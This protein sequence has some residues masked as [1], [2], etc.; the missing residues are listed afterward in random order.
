MTQGTS[1]RWTIHLQ[2]HITSFVSNIVSNSRVYSQNPIS[3]QNFPLNLSCQITDSSIIRYSYTVLSQGKLSSF[4]LDIGKEADRLWFWRF[5]I[6]YPA[7][8]EAAIWHP[9]NK[10]SPTL[11]R[12]RYSRYSRSRSFDNV[13]Y[14]SA[15]LQERKDY[16]K[17]PKNFGKQL[18]TALYFGRPIPREG[19]NWNS[20]TLVLQLLRKQKPCQTTRLL[21]RGQMIHSASPVRTAVV[22]GS[23]TSDV[24]WLLIQSWWWHTEVK[25]QLQ[26]IL[27]MLCTW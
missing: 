21:L 6:T 17:S 25:D 11:V 26:L 12:P 10:E 18:D 8:I 4:D 20:C 3:L 5:I 22:M 14:V 13:R 19:L 7:F 15:L 9:F 24:L 1:Y 23:G 2:E 27:R 16:P